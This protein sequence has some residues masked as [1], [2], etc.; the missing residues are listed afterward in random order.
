MRQMN[1]N[2]PIALTFNALIIAFTLAPL[3][4]V[5]LVAFTPADTLTLPTT[6]LSLR[7]FRAAFAHP[8]FLQSFWNSLWLALPAA[9]IGTLLA[10]PAGLAITRFNF[11]GRD[12]LNALFLSP[13]I[14][15][16]LVLGVAMLRLFTLIGGTGSFGFLIMAHALIVTP[17]TL[18]LVVAALVG[19]DRSVEHAALSLGASQA[20]VF[21]RI[22]LPMILPGVTGGWLLAFINSFDE[23]TMSIFVTAPSTVTLPVRM[24][25]YATESIDPLMAAVSALMVAV[26]ACA[27][28]LIDRVYGLDRI[29]VGT[30]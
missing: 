8:D 29:L 12:F 22:T 21:R 2:G 11:P 20:A 28:V 30:K 25:S 13:L 17:Y 6:A 14:I 26:T 24:Y 10:V 9:T 23:V 5:C 3:V 7:W 18:R 1:K 15:P 19:F 27:M 16:H 4:V